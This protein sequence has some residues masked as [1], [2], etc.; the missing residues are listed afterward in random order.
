M[1]Q[2]LRIILTLLLLIL[3][4][5]SCNTENEGIFKTISQSYPKLT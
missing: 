5:T 2:K 1:K 3:I 4:L